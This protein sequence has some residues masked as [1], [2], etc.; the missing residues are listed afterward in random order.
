MGSDNFDIVCTNS[1]GDDE[2]LRVMDVFGSVPNIDGCAVPFQ[3][4]HEIIHGTV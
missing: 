4:T 1:R 2:H 3:R